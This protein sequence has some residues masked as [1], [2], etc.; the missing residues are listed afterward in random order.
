MSYSEQL[1]DPRWQKKRLEI[2]SRDKFACIYCGDGTETLHVHHWY[3]VS[4][5]D[6]WEYPEWSMQTLCE[7]CHGSVH[8]RPNQQNLFESRYEW[9]ERG[10]QINESTMAKCKVFLMGVIPKYEVRSKDWRRFVKALA[11]LMM[12][13][14]LV[15]QLDLQFSQADKPDLPHEP[16]TP[17]IITHHVI[18]TP[19]NGSS[20]R[21][22]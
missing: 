20:P 6:P 15:G 19:N 16:T 12:D 14:E 13:D 18:H 4:G 3:Y 1:K 2:L 7:S 11:I 10:R 8:E 22:S 5:R 21:T 17:T 9:L